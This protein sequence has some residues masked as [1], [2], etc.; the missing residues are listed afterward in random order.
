MRWVI[1]LWIVSVA[2]VASAADAQLE[3][4]PCWFA[5]AAKDPN[6][7]IECAVLRVPER[8]GSPPDGREVTLPV[9][10]LRV[11]RASHW[12]TLVPGGGGPGAPVGLES[13][14]A[15]ITLSN[16]ESFALESRGDVVLTDQRGAGLSQPVL[17]CDELRAATLRWL[18]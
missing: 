1:A 12:A 18:G 9:V 5:Y 15:P 16:Y 7:R 3:K 10:R 17:Q 2:V 8:W 4:R 13:D 11:G 6:T 14:E